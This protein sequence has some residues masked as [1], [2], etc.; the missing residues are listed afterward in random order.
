MSG[1]EFSHCVTALVE[2]PAEIAFRFLADPLAVGGWSLGCMG[3]EPAGADGLHS[4]TSLF[5]GA[6]GWF[7]IAAHPEVG[8]IDYWI[9]IETAL[10]P[11][12]SARVVAAEVCGLKS[13]R[14]YVTLTAWR[15]A[16]MTDARWRQLC[17]A[18]EAEIWL[19]KSQ[20]ETTRRG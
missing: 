1:D 17:A 14:C 8:L 3:T 15:T 6:K 9:G 5:D 2:T 20:I 4:G 7:R 11:R 16:E 12:I 10:Q 18:H 13:A 19:I